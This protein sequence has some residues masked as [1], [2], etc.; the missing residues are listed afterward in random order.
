MDSP[1]S[2]SQ[3]QAHMNLDS[4]VEPHRIYELQNFRN[5]RRKMFLIGP[6]T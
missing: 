4:M 5:F 3:N 1:D 2:V 6:N